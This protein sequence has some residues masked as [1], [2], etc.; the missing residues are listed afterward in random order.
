MQKEGGMDAEVA[1]LIIIAVVA[2]MALALAWSREALFFS[3]FF[4]IAVAIALSEAV[5][6]SL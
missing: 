5:H 3:V 2:L 1:Q 4:A 6:R